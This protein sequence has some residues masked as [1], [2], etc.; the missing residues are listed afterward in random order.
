MASLIES[1]K[2]SVVGS[3]E[4]SPNW[5]LVFFNNNQKMFVDISRPHCKNLFEGIFNGQ[6]VYP[7]DFSRYLINAHHMLLFGNGKIAKQKSLNLAIKSFELN[8]SQAPIIEILRASRFNELRPRVVTFCKKYL[9]EFIENK[10]TW[11][12]RGGYY[13][14]NVAA[15]HASNFLLEIARRQGKTELAKTYKAIKDKC[16]NE[17]KRMMNKKRW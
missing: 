16:F 7:N 12:S 5:Q 8:P 3:L 15:L 14:K 9:G 17:Q 6:T 1:K 2:S 13:H 11:T 10:D 4:Y